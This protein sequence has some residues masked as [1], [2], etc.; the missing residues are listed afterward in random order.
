MLHLIDNS[1]A[2]RILK[3]SFLQEL[4]MDLYSQFLNNIDVGYY[5][6]CLINLIYTAFILN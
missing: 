2:Q 4:F 5:S 1:I 6:F 3:Q